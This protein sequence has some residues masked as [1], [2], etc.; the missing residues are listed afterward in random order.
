MNFLNRKILSINKTDILGKSRGSL[1]GLLN[2]MSLK[3]PKFN[4]GYSFLIAS[5]VSD[6]DLEENLFSERKSFIEQKYGLGA[7]SLDEFIELLDSKFNYFETYLLEKI[8]D[9]FNIINFAEHSYDKGMWYNEDYKRDIG[10]SIDEMNCF[11]NPNYFINQDNDC[12]EPTIKP[13]IALDRLMNSLSFLDCG[14]GL[15][16]AVFGGFRWAMGQVPFDIVFDQA[17][18]P[19][20]LSKNF[21]GASDDD[22]S[23][24]SL[25]NPLYRLYDRVE[26][27]T[28]SDVKVGD[29]CYIQGVLN[30]SS[31]HPKGHLAGY[32]VICTGEN[33]DGEPLFMG[34]GHKLFDRPK[35]YDDLKRILLDGYNEKSCLPNLVE[36]AT[37]IEGLKICFRLS[38][39]K[40]KRFILSSLKSYP[41]L[42]SNRIKAL[43]WGESKIGDKNIPILSCGLKSMILPL[44]YSGM[45]KEINFIRDSD[46]DIYVSIDGLS[47]ENLAMIRK[48]VISFLKLSSAGKRFDDLFYLRATK[49]NLNELYPTN[50]N[51][52]KRSKSACDSSTIASLLKSESFSLEFYDGLSKTLSSAERGSDFIRGDVNS[53]KIR[54]EII[55]SP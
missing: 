49:G 9:V 42:E 27:E 52:T 40:V 5:R 13:S 36:S 50:E 16:C 23:N 6:S 44:L 48:F 53:Y 37:E 11:G 20:Y 22:R 10:H 38:S 47:Q 4:F 26:F 17:L 25:K 43:S 30:Y 18:S 3:L 39:Q 8:C 46:K 15:Q 12:L 33:Y 54:A 35:S 41:Y 7:T 51:K 29:I 14:L 32:N 45:R 55:N 24:L 34:I 19:F 21:F 1:G 2:G 28:I 31:R